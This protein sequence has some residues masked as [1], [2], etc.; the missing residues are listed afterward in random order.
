MKEKNN[1]ERKR[2]KNLKKNKGGNF[3]NLKKRWAN[4]KKTPS[5]RLG[6]VYVKWFKFIPKQSKQFHL[7]LVHSWVLVYSSPPY[8]PNPNPKKVDNIKGEIIYMSTPR[9]TA[10]SIKSSLFFYRFW[11]L[12]IYLFIYV[13][14][15]FNFHLFYLCR[16]FN[17]YYKIKFWNIQLLGLNFRPINSLNLKNVTVETHLDLDCPTNTRESYLLFF[18]THYLLKFSQLKN[19]LPKLRFEI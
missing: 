8:P 14:E 3:W 16:N 7:Q 15:F 2:R 17:N 5:S 4:E 1:K 6:L 13:S 18:Y 12:F 10:Q 9:P 19:R 11:H